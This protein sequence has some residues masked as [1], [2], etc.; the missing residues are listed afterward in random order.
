MLACHEGIVLLGLAK[1]IN[2]VPFCTYSMVKPF[3]TG[4]NGNKTLWGS[5][6]EN[7]DTGYRTVASAIAYAK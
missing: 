7:E 5:K 4:L 1:E 6:A 3:N 2:T